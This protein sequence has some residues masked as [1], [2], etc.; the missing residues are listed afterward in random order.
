MTNNPNDNRPNQPDPSGFNHPEGYS[1]YEPL[2]SDSTQPTYGQDQYGQDQ[3]GQEQYGQGGY[4]QPAYGQSEYGQSQYGQDYYG[5]QGYGQPAPYGAP[6]VAPASN[7]MAVGALVT[8]II[9]LLFAV[10][11]FPLGIILGI[12]ATVLGFIA[13][14]KANTLE[15][16]AQQQGMPVNSRKGLAIG[17]LATGIISLVI[18]LALLVFGINFARELMDSGI[19][20]A[21]QEFANDPQALNECLMREMENN[22]NLPGGS[23]N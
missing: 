9:G 3:Y 10:L 4:E 1:S 19:I 13:M 6:G 14:R 18:S 2:H 12:V 11:F 7:G 21:C 22:P 15:A 20:E 23:S 16:T 5:Q 8:G 17:G